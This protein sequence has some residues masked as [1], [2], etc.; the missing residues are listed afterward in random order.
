MIKS[1]LKIILLTNILIKKCHP[2]CT[3][4][5]N[6]RGKSTGL[7]FV[8]GMS[9]LL[10]SETDACERSRCSVGKTWI[11]TH[12]CPP[13]L[14]TPFP[15]R[16][17]I[18]RSGGYSQVLL[19]VEL[20]SFWLARAEIMCGLCHLRHI[21]LIAHRLFGD[22]QCLSNNEVFPSVKVHRRCFR[23][24]TATRETTNIDVNT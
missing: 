11:W 8:I 13:I 21:W 19:E 2:I 3:Y 9:A 10:W 23:I 17:K 12:N 1:F 4:C 22:I 20:C 5:C 6:H 15:L 14:F 7:M 24:E 18:P 16:S